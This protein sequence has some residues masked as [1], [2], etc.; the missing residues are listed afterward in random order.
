MAQFALREAD[1]LPPA[2][3]YLAQRSLLLHRM[4]ARARAR[5]REGKDGFPLDLKVQIFITTK[6]WLYAIPFQ[7]GF[8]KAPNAVRNVVALAI[9]QAPVFTVRGIGEPAGT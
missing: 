1:S 5:S 2:S 7:S 3:D 4:V 9:L 8:R 6:P